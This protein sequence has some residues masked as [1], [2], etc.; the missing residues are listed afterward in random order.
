MSFAVTAKCSFSWSI[1]RAQCRGLF[2][3]EG[4]VLRRVV[5]YIL[6]YEEEGATKS[7]RSKRDEFSKAWHL[8]GHVTYSMLTRVIDH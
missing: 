2:S 4:V 6:N 3:G 5:F 7:T 1:R 8:D